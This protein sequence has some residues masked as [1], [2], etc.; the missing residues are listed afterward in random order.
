[1]SDFILLT[2]FLAVLSRLVHD[3]TCTCFSFCSL[4][5]AVYYRSKDL[6]LKIYTFELPPTDSSAFQV[7]LPILIVLHPINMKLD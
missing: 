3:S 6:K 5:L 1:M 4:D 2:A 7:I